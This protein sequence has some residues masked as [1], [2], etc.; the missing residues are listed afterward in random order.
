M[1]LIDTGSQNTLVLQSVVNSLS[2]LPI[3]KVRME[4]DGY[5]TVG[6]SRFYDLVNLDV[7][8]LEGIITITA[9]VVDSLPNRVHMPGRSSM[10]EKIKR[11]IVNMADISNRDVT[12]LELII[13][14]DNYHK[15]VDG[16]KISEDIYTVNTGFLRFPVLGFLFV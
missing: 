15:F 13:G 3:G 5:E 1:A 8:S 9:M 16:D 12:C 10:I 4:I 11:K 14:V 6:K 7:M 2:I